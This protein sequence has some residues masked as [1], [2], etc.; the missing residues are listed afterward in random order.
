M[1]T[2]KYIRENLEEVKFSL[3]NKKSE[4]DI[5][6]L[7]SLD[8]DRRKYIHE[9]EELRSNRNL[10]SENISLIKKKGESAFK[11][12]EAMQKVSGKIKEL[13][14]KLKDIE[15]EIETQIYFIP[16]IV[17]SSVPRGLDASGN[18][19]VKSWGEKTKKDFEIKEHIE[20]GSIL[21]LFDFKRA[22]KMAGSSFPLYTGLGAKLERSLLNFMLD[23]HVE[24]NYLEIS[25]PFLANY[26]SMRNT[27]QI[28]KFKDDMYFIPED[29]L[30][31]IPTAEVPLTNYHQNEILIESNLPYCYTAYTPCFRREA[32]SYGQE[33][34]GLSRIH[35]FNKVELVRFVHPENSYTELEILLNNAESILQA[36]G[37]HYRIIELCSG[38]LSFSAAKCYDIEVWSP[39]NKKYLEVSSCSNFEDFQSRRANIR[40]NCNNTGKNRL[41]HTLNGSGVA[42]PRLMIALL[43]HYQ[44]ED[45]T[46]NLPTILHPYF[47]HKSIKPS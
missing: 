29:N 47:G 32:G 40:F 33:T 10:V 21:G 42:T 12:I 5:D 22:V 28:P 39:Y 8:V 45:G 30:F 34:K 13:E 46:I 16:N 17:H 18:I 4:V 9:V 3:L 43:E 20:L 25:P 31:C 2:L 23:Q 27:G 36:L 1:K 19:S 38:D 24:N 6:K 14:N 35:Q 44:E 11:E 37:L 41:V 26:N 7:I 15:L